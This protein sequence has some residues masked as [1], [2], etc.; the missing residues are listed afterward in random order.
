MTFPQN[1]AVNNT[2]VE[3]Q[4]TYYAGKVDKYHCST[5]QADENSI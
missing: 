2:K 1:F 3:Y 4:K 5:E